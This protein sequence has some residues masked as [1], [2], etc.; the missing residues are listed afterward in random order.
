MKLIGKGFTA[1]VYKGSFKTTGGDDAP[2]AVKIL[3]DDYTPL[4]N[5]AELV[6]ELQVLSRVHHGN[7]VAYIG[8]TYINRTLHIVTEYMDG[9][10]L[11]D[12]I[13]NEKTILNCQHIYSAFR[14]DK[15]KRIFQIFCLY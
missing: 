5:T 13:R 14:N 2:V 12:Y 10:S 11:H 1:K 15:T 8:Y 6:D 9:G 4:V 7:V 3:N